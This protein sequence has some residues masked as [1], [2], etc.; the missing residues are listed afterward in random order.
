MQPL[1]CSMLEEEEEE[2]EG[3]LP[4]PVPASD[5]R[6]YPAALADYD[7]AVG[8]AEVFMDTLRKLH[9]SMGT[10]FM[11]PVVG[12]KDLDLHRLFVEVTSRGGVS[13]ERKWKE[14][15]AVFKFPASATNAS[16]IL[17]KYYVSLLYH[18]E[19]IYYGGA[20]FWVPRP[21]PAPA[22]GDDAPR[23]DGATSSSRPVSGLIDGKFESGYLVTVR[24][25]S[26]ELRGVLY[27]VQSSP[28][29]PPRRKRRKKCEMRKRDPSHP[30]PNRSGYNFFFA[31][32][33]ARLKPHYHGRDREISRIIGKSWNKLQDCDRA[34]YQ[35]EARK[36]KERYRAEMEA[37]RER[38]RNNGDNS[39][40]SHGARAVIADLNAGLE[41]DVPPTSGA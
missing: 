23:H 26:E 28:G 35:E 21:P 12:G 10:K 17:R 13:K 7:D 31:E 41:N 11:I 18:Y 2:E 8:S 14:V 5:F 32:Q 15:T 25:G 36:D 22:T 4:A 30:K 37:Y 34:V 20:K 1:P 3:T 24:V 29:K 19:Q 6:P 40:S 16:Y 27:Q 33:H 38:Q 9:A 39:D